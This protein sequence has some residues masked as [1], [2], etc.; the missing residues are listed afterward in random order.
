MKD[1][2]WYKININRFS[3]EKKAGIMNLLILFTVYSLYELMDSSF[4]F[5]T[6]N[7]G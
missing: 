2:L 1:K 3:K 5:D 6:L 7:L 4:W